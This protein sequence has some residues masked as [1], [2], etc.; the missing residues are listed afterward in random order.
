MLLFFLLNLLFPGESSL[1]L[2]TL[3]PKKYT[4]VYKLER[5][6]QNNNVGTVYKVRIYVDRA[7]LKRDL[8]EA[9]H[10]LCLNRLVCIVHFWSKKAHLKFT[11]ATTLSV[12]EKRS[13]LGVVNYHLELQGN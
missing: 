3:V 10:D 8:R 4:V 12:Q 7:T 9:V 13:R 11:K 5:T 6:T 2:D 1:S